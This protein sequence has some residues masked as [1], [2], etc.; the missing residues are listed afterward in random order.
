MRT[1]TLFLITIVAGTMLL[2]SLAMAQEG[3][4]RSQA[5]T[6]LAGRVSSTEEGAMEGVLVSPKKL[7]PRL[8][9]Q[10]SATSRGDI[11]QHL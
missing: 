1:T 7:V 8:R 2:P 11:I 3:S 5:S 6:A 4:A 9:L 10:W